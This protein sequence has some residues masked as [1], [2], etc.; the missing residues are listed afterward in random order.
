MI[1]TAE[2]IRGYHSE[3]A[4]NF[5][6]PA[7]ITVPDQP[8]SRGVRIR[9]GRLSAFGLSLAVGLGAIGCASQG[10]GIKTP[11]N[12]FPKSPEQI[13][14]V[15]TDGFDVGDYTI[16][17]VHQQGVATEGTALSDDKVKT[18]VE[19]TLVFGGKFPVIPVD[20]YVGDY[21]ITT[22]YTVLPS[23]ETIHGYMIAKDSA[24]NALMAGYPSSIPAVTI[25]DLET[26]DRVSH[27]ALLESGDFTNFDIPIDG[28]DFDL[29]VETCNN[30]LNINPTK[31]ADEALQA[32]FGESIE[33]IRFLF[34]K[35]GFETIC[36]SYALAASS[37]H[38][39]IS[40][41]DY[42]KA[43]SEKFLEPETSVGLT[44]SYLVFSKRDWNSL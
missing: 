26:G 25:T 28:N 23:V 3:K 34:L 12:S 41:S 32:H 10:D 38:A 1:A 20:I 18:A 15:L 17:I 37:K 35:L 9:S 36:N 11:D 24:T 21:I 14:L 13:T 39:G 30:M 5:Q 6:N 4:R 7:D 16:S 40:Y 44:I 31:Q 27:L 29:Y 43:A 42:R 33:E 22:P 2:V 19:K 8:S